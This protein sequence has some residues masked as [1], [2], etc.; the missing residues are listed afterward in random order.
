MITTTTSQPRAIT[1]RVAYAALGATL[2]ALIAVEAINHSTGDWQIAAFGLGP[3]LALLYGAGPDLDH[4]QIH[5]RAVGVYNIAHRLWGPIALAA[6]ASLGVL[7][8]G[9]FIGALTWA[10]HVAADRAVG[11]G[12]RTRDGYQRP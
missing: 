6:L 5:P 10:L 8:V 11:Y 1:R 7:S 2:L 12:L 9:Y 3:D 4:G